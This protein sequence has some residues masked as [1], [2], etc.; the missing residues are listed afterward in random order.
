M[1]PARSSLLDLTPAADATA[2]CPGSSSGR[3]LRGWR[4]R[5]LLTQ[6]Q[7]AERAGLNVRTVRR[8]ENGGPLQPRTS[9]I[10]LLA[11]ALDL[12]GEER[13]LLAAVAGGPPRAAIVPRQLP[14][15]VTALV[16]RERELA[17]LEDHL[18]AGPVTAVCVEGMAGAG[19]T[20]LAVH[21][22]HRLAHRFPGGQLFV[23][24]RGHAPGAAPVEP[25]EALARLLRA[26]GVPAAGVPEHLDDRAA[27]YRSV[28]AERRVLV[29]LDDAADEHQVLP[30]L[31]GGQDCR[32]VV[33][34]RR[35]LS[36]LPDAATLP[37]GVL[38][39]AA[40]AAL[41][42]QV[43]GPERVAGAPAEELSE[44]V[45]RCGLLPLAVGVAAARLR[46]HATWSVRH[47]L[48]RLAGDRL[49]ELRAGRH[50]VAAALDLSY[51]RL[52]PELR[53]AYRLLGTGPGADFGAG[54]AAEL[55]GTSVPRAERLLDQLLEVHL[56]QETA[57]GRYHL[58]G[59]LRDHARG[60]A[61]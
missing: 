59:L 33:T 2:S 45:A 40:A 31:P 32:V 15:D 18:G 20:A 35:R 46:A 48:D 25:G 14:A 52:P 60:R 23:D 21:A 5:A 29:V 3:L 11:Q 17:A 28:L 58:P 12:D 36:C 41:F 55:L 6:E 8:L 53:R 47:L 49:A 13:A 38:P 9:S 54:A 22:A 16:G 37:L 30:L 51:D 10:L 4:K 24:L 7:L 43:A 61:R 57:P 26:L 56:V 34:G 44:V 1:H 27:L 42:A 39:Q 50:D 19:K